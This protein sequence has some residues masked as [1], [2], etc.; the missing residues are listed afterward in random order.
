VT[1]SFSDETMPDGSVRGARSALLRIVAHPMRVTLG[2]LTPGAETL[3]VT[4]AGFAQD[5]SARAQRDLRQRVA[6]ALEDRTAIVTEDAVGVFP[7]TGTD[8]LDVAYCTRLGTLLVQLV[9]TG[10]CEGRIDPRGALVADLYKA[11]L[12]RALAVDRLFAMCYLVER[13]ALDDLATDDTLGATS[14][15]WPLVAQFVRRTSF[16]LLAAYTERSQLEPTGAAITDRLTTVYTRPVLDAVLAKSVD[17]ATRYGDTLSLILFD[18]DRLAAINDEHGYGVGDRIL[19]RLGIL[20]QGYFRHYDWVARHGG[21]SIAVLL[22]RTDG[23]N[24]ADLAQ[25][26][27]TTVAERL[28]LV[29]HRT[30]RPVHVTV[31]AAVLNVCGNSGELM[32][33]V[34]LMFDAEAALGRAKQRG[35]NCVERV[36]GYS[37][38]NAKP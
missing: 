38:A 5:D 29:N 3:V 30:D 20:V 25:Q 1:V 15:D 12:E 37:G 10:V 13:I 23:E 9:S 17:R 7:V 18:V 28:E 24:A 11:A 35:R 34:R 36:D 32:D 27:C 8:T 33:P 26:V 19:E 21:D 4:P 22:S 16:D 6:A 2:P 31:S 14:E